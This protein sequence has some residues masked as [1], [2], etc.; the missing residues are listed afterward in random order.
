M[1]TALIA[2]STGLI[3]QSL[4]STLLNS[5]EYEKVIAI[6]RTPLN[7]KHPKLI[8]SIVDFNHL[9]D[10]SPPCSVHHV[11]CCL[12]TT[13]K[14][15]G[16]KQAFLKVDYTYVNQLAQWAQE[17]HCEHFS[18]ISSV[19]ASPKASSFYL[20]TKGN[21]ETSL[22]ALNIRSIHIFRP[23]LLLGERKEFRMG[24]KIS[25]LLL[26]LLKPLLRGKLRKYRAIKASHVARAMYE[27]A[28]EK[29]VGISVFEGK[30][31]SYR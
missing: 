24:E 15:A 13:I 3:G 18:V 23:S 21:M 29:Q 16:S 4:L 17:H 7:I 27:H 19:G 12:G 9:P 14:K 28:Q 1:K 26:V 11:F 6:V 22:S 8:E 25:E 10:F 30:K 5:N 31:I 20:H 2:G